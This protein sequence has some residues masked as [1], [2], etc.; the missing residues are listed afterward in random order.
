MT[1]PG[2]ERWSTLKLN[3]Q[4]VGTLLTIRS[5]HVKPRGSETILWVRF[6]LLP[7]SDVS[8][9]FWFSEWGLPVESFGQKT[10]TLVSLICSM[11]PGTTPQSR[12]K[13][14]EDRKQSKRVC[15]LLLGL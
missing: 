2:P 11:F 5:T 1:S 6:Q 3:S 4:C 14:W 7:L 9:T 8:G 15:A 12:A 13:Q 10:R